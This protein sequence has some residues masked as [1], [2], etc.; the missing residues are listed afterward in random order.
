MK[1]GAT[2]E[3]EALKFVT[4]NPAKQLRIDPWVG[5]LEPGKEADFVIWSKS[6]LDSTTVCLQTWIEGRKFFD[7]EGEA[8]RSEALEKERTALLDKAKRLQLV[9]G[10]S[11]GGEKEKE[12][13]F[14][15]PLEHGYDNQ[16]RHCVEEE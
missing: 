2:P 4:L 10:S 16:D 9:G 15:L 12:K 1:Y 7:R 6:P 3:Q 14:E 8:G 13:F 11:E 5:S